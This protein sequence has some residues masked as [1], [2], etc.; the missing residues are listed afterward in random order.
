MKAIWWGYSFQYVRLTGM[1]C[2]VL[3]T[4]KYYLHVILTEAN[5][6]VLTE[7]RQKLTNEEQRPT[8]VTRLMVQ[9]PVPMGFHLWYTHPV[10]IKARAAKHECGTINSST[11]TTNFYWN[12]RPIDHFSNYFRSAIA[13]WA[14][15]FGYPLTI[16][17]VAVALQKGHLKTPLR[18][19][20]HTNSHKIK[21]EEDKNEKKEYKW[22]QKHISWA[23]KQH[24][25]CAGFVLMLFHHHENAW[26]IFG[27]TQIDTSSLW[28]LIERHCKWENK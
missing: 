23:T 6:Y 24:R 2:L 22:Q 8:Q 27:R 25:Y 9:P 18:W 13:V 26:V 20:Y 5:G 1:H 7:M 17:S 10:A 14:R 28:R 21:L 15:P 4:Y 3:Q 12:Q 11:F 19:F 16:E